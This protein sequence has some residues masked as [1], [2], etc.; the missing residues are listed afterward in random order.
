M[1]FVATLY[2]GFDEDFY[3]IRFNKLVADDFYIYKYTSLEPFEAI[4]VTEVENAD[5][6]VIIELD[7]NAYMQFSMRDFCEGMVDSG[8][9]AEINYKIAVVSDEE[10]G[11]FE[12]ISEVFATWLEAI[13]KVISAVFKIF[14]K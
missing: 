9:D 3:T 6:S 4:T 11:F 12:M 5:V 13:K 10:K 8:E 14:R 7:E 1:S 2:Y